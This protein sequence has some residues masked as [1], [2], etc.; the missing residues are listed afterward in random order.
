MA[1]LAVLGGTF[2]PFHLGHLYL[3]RQAATDFG[4]KVHIIPNGAPPHRASPEASWRQRLA[5]CRQATAVESAVS[6]GEEELPAKPG[7][8]VDTLLALKQRLPD[9]TLLLIIGGDAADDFRYWRQPEKILQ[10]AHLLVV[11]RP[12]KL[13]IQR[14]PAPTLDNKNDLKH[15]SGGAYRWHCHPPAI[16][17]SDCRSAVRRGDTAELPRLLPGAVIDYIRQ[18]RLYRTAPSAAG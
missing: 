13:Q 1:T 12:P 8:T 11:P 17:A 2:D 15:G 10:L 9:T 5:M 7:Y 4:C 6:V 16:T 18:Q 3:A 14:L